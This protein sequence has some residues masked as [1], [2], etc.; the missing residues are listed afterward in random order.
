MRDS[1]DGAERAFH[2]SVCIS[3]RSDGVS[4][5]PKRGPLEGGWQLEFTD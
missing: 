2:L 5:S 1:Q 4:V 3:V